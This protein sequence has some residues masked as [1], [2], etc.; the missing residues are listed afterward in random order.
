MLTVAWICLSVWLIL[1]GALQAFD[2]KFQNR[3]KIM[4]FLAIIA[5]VVLLI[6]HLM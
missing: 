4:G 2:I 6:A 3:D 5:G 1:M